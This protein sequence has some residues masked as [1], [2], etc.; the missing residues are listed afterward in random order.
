MRGR[1]QASEPSTGLSSSL[2]SVTIVSVVSSRPAIEA[3]FCSARAHDLGRVDDA[4]L[5]HVDVLARERVEAA[6]RALLARPSRRPPTRRRR[7][8]RRSGAAAPRRARST[9]CAPKLSSP[10]SLSAATRLGRAQQRDAAAGDDAFL[11]RGARG[12][13]RVL[14]PVLLLLHLGLG[15]AADLDDG[16]AAGQLARGAPGASRGRSRTWSSRSGCGSAAQRSSMSF[17]LPAPPTMIGAVLG[18]LHA[19]GAAEV[20]DRDLVERD[21]EVLGDRRCRRSGRRCRPGRPCGG[22]RSPAP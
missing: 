22:R 19:L 11:D 10:W 17:F 18:D 12:V 3:A 4:G 8:S 16:D 6:G 13:E 2:S 14:D 1:A 20:L 21:A 7:R 9:I 5:E 15:V